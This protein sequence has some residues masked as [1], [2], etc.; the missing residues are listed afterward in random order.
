M[1]PR[2]GGET[3]KF[4][5]RYEGAWAIRHALYVLLGAGTSIT[6]EPGSSLGDGVE[7]VYRHGGGTQ[8][9]QVKRQNRNANSWNVASLRDKGVW[10]SLR[11]HVDAGR[12]FHFVS[13][14][15]ARSLDELA[16]R[17]RR[18]DTL[19]AFEA[20]WLTDGLQGPFDALAEADVFGSAA[21]AWRM[22]RG[23]WV[24]WHN[25]R[26]LVH[27]NA[28]L[29]EQVLAGAPGRLAAVGLGD[30]L[31]NS[32]GTTLDGP[33]I[34]ARLGEYGLRR[35]SRTD[36]AEATDAVGEATRRWASSVERA[37]FR[38]AIPRETTDQL[39]AQVLSDAQ[40]V[41]VL[42]GAAG[43]GKS[44]V[45]HQALDALTKL[46][47][48]VVAFRLD[49]LAPFTSTHELGLRIGLPG[50]PIRALAAA[51][52]GRRC[53]LIVDQLD[54]ISMASGRIP[55]TFDAVADLM[56]E[57][58]AYSAMRIVLACRE[59]DAKADP[60]IRRLTASDRCA[61]IAVGPLTDAQVDAALASMGLAASR[62]TPSQRALLR[63]PL[64]LVLLAEVADPETAL[65]FR[66][67]RQLFDAFWDTKRKDC[68]RRQP[69]ARFHE[70]ISAV[71]AAMSARQSLSVPDSLLDA[72]A[73]AASA[74]VLVS[75]HVLVREGRQLAFFHESFFDYAF[76]RDWHRRDESLVAFLASGDQELFRRGQVRQVLD[77]LRDLDSERFAQEVEGL[78]TSPEIRYHLKDVT[79]AV[80]RGL[81]APTA[82]EWGAVAR[83]LDTRPLFRDQLVNAVSNAAWFRRADDEAALDDWL[84][85]ADE[86]EHDWAVRMMAA[87]AD[88]FPDRVARLLEPHTSDPRLGSLLERVVRFADLAGSRSLFD[89]LLDGARSGLLAGREHRVWIS[90]QD[91]ASKQPSWTVELI[92][93]MV[94][95]RPDALRLEDDGRVGVLLNRDDSA[96]RVVAAAAVGAPEEFCAR[97]LPLL[98]AAMAATALPPKEGCPVYDKHFTIRYPGDR[99]NDLGEAL[100][101]GAAKALRIV[102]SQDPA[103][104]RGLV[105][106][107]ASV[108]YEAAQW[109]LYQVLI[110]AGSTLAPW[111]VEILLQGRYR[112]LS[113]YGSNIVWGSREV[114]RAVGNALPADTLR[115]VA[116]M[117]LHLR[118]PP[119]EEFSL[120]HEFTLLT[121][122]PEN[123]LSERAARRLGELRRRHDDMREPDEPA[124]VTGGFIGSPIPSEAAQRMSDDQW[125]GAMRKHSRD[126]TDWETFTGGA[127]ELSH[128][129]RSM[130]AA[131][132]GRFSRLAVRM[133]AGMHPAYG[134]S[135]LLGLGDAEPYGDPD[136]VFAA[137]RHLSGQCRPAHDRWLGWAMRKYLTSV[138]LDLVETLLDR[139]LGVDGTGDLADSDAMI[140]GGEGD[141]ESE[142]DAE[143][144][145]LTAGIN[146]VRG[147][148]VESLG[149]LLVHASDSSRAALVVPHLRRI[150]ADPSLPVRACAAHLLH[151]ALG[152]DRPAVAEAF[153]VLVRAPDRLLASRKVFRLFVALC[154][155]DPVAGGPVRERMLRSPVP[156]VRRSGGRVAAL[157]AMEWE[158]T[159]LLAEVLAGKD[160]AQRQGAADV[161]AQR[162]VNTADEDLAHHALV[163][164]FHDPEEGVR[165]AAAAVAAALRG[166][167]LGPVR[168]TVTAL[169]DSDAFRPA[170]PQLLITLEEAPDRVDELILACVRRFLTVFGA[171]SADLATRAAADAHHI[172]ELLV[173]AHA[174]ATSAARRSE[175]LDLLDQLLLRGS[176]GVAEAIGSADRG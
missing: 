151:A 136:T 96:L 9:H 175:I 26:D 53:V 56:D 150:A 118:L 70:A 29:A 170:L 144:D 66:T 155:G 117:L 37:L 4:G 130:T 159:D 30:L 127:R 1:T 32:L 59:F 47:T 119:D 64:H 173:R 169:I 79:L 60:R 6:L 100:F 171:A 108:P 105:T 81:E 14:V 5:N 86:R 15:P 13:L 92:G 40:Q 154:H 33:A 163:Q 38:P 22:L 160:G 19:A 12:A 55:E 65:S 167:R 67:T 54:A 131:A 46:D 75:E 116:D 10:S 98:L 129:L 63:S 84:T 44:A 99:P 72:D 166:R 8:V 85:S 135:L 115:Q 104:A 111:S 18:S 143:H 114:L 141:L 149:D 80:L 7:F 28:V 168:R 23:L 39:V 126:R 162:L 153:A 93:A 16:D 62:V 157:A 95:D 123:R 140:G 25:E 88:V 94:V 161:C 164:F 74:D 146:T 3:D 97:V 77:H 110:E 121:A 50:S 61:H 73:L 148:A 35:V 78:L 71:V 68:A 36:G 90:V 89:L 76:A 158:T 2:P 48:P 109:L 87:G 133:D 31:L 41:T 152:Y 103:R 145:L 69:S 52:K 58:M 102:A 91:L 112:L 156:A 83:V 165:E 34:S 101:Q 49:R 176:Y 125:L 120:W 172:G 27:T 138:P 147:S 20:E 45:L 57:A 43:G 51:A 113:G 128:V 106:G 124:G 142:P 24:E 11:S 122:L 134:A 42:T 107:L 17:A 21:M 137:V 132:P 82:G 174:Q 139:V